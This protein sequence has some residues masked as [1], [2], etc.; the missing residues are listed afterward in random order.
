M[1]VGMCGIKHSPSGLV[2]PPTALL[3]EHKILWFLVNVVV[4]VVV[5]VSVKETRIFQ[6]HVCG[7]AHAI[8]IALFVWMHADALW[9][10]PEMTLPSLLSLRR[11]LGGARLA[12]LVVCS[13]RASRA[14]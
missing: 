6:A 12:Q 7:A 13:E 5:V 4:L 8:F 2:P 11:R 1:C 9:H 10:P 14:M 3:A